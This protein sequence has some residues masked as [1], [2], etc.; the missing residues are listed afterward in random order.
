MFS[1]LVTGIINKIMKSGTKK[2]NL[3]QSLHLCFFSFILQ[4]Q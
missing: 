4:S 2:V 1:Y 3:L